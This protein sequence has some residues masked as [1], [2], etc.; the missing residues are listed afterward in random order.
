MVLRPNAGHGLFILE[1]SRSQTTHHSRQDLSGCVISVSQRPLPDNTQHSQQTDIHAPSGIQTHNLSRWARYQIPSNKASHPTRTD[2]STI[3]QCIFLL[4]TWL[5]LG[6]VQQ[7]PQCQWSIS[8]VV[9]GK[10]GP[11]IWIANKSV[12]LIMHFRRHIFGIHY[13][14]GLKEYIG[15]NSEKYNKLML[16]CTQI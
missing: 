15:M 1:V 13:P 5:P 6:E 12:K 2:N 10:A 8:L 7:C 11:V 16:K 14:Q 3:H 4:H 9:Q